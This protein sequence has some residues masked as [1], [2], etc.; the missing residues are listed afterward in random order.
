[1]NKTLKLSQKVLLSGNVG[2]YNVLNPKQRVSDPNHVRIV[3]V[4]TDQGYGRAARANQCQTGLLRNATA[5]AGMIY[6][7]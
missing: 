7:A 2:V 1:L 4:E 5:T 6:R 3:M